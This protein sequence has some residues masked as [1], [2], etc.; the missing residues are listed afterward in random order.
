MSAIAEILS[1]N[2]SLTSLRPS[3]K[4]ICVICSDTLVAAEASVLLADNEVSYLWTCDTC[5]CGFVTKHL[6]TKPFA[7]I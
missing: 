4:P 2:S 3:D 1:T 6:A 5:G 7:C